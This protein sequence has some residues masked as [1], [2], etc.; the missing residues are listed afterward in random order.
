[1]SANGQSF[2]VSIEGKDRPGLAE[3]AEAALAS[4]LCRVLSLRKVTDDVS[5]RAFLWLKANGGAARAGEIHGTL[6]LVLRRF[7]VSVTV[8]PADPP[9]LILMV[10]K[11]GHCLED[12]LQ[13]IANGEIR[14]QVSAIVSNHENFEGLAAQYGV[15]FHFWPVTP[16]TKAQQEAKLLELFKKS[17]AELLVLARYLQILSPGL[18]ERLAGRI[19]NI[20]P[21]LLPAFKG[22]RAYDQAE[23]HGVRFVGATAHYVTAGLD[24]GPVIEQSVFRISG[25][26]S[27]SEL[28]KRGR[29]A[30]IA[31]LARAVKLH[32]EGRVFLIG[33]RTVIA[34]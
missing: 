31:A 13:R 11:L 7:G 1:M 25:S 33:R 30:E 5:G 3:G 10:S 28:A 20:H 27:A 2:I 15:P 23:A 32:S 26:E 22:A 4:A 29:Q 34:D 16:A 8:K 6:E 24:E 17:R 19:I 21:S 12:L 14:A 9:R 18:C